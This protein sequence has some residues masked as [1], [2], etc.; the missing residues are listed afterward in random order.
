MAKS[1]THFP[2]ISGCAD[3]ADSVDSVDSADG[4]HAAHSGCSDHDEYTVNI[5]FTV[6]IVRTVQVR[7]KNDRTLRNA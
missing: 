2:Y 5:S 1:N 6:P 3:N 7:R 4:E